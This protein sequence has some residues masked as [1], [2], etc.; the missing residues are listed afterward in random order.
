MLL[1]DTKQSLQLHKA[2]LIIL[3]ARAGATLISISI[4]S[5]MLTLIRNDRTENC[6]EKKYDPL[7]KY[8]TTTSKKRQII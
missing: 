2:S 3:V 1:V 6:L 8:V 7:V 5:F 4:I